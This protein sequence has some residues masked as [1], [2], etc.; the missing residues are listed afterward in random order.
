MKIKIQLYLIN[1]GEKIEAR[2]KRKLEL[3]PDIKKQILNAHIQEE[4]GKCRIT[5]ELKVENIANSIKK[6]KKE[7]KETLL[8]LLSGEGKE[9]RKRVHEIKSKFDITF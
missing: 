4:H 3:Y 7:D 9:I 1:T 8:L 6:L 5:V 2:K